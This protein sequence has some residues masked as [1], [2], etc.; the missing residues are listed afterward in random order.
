MWKWFKKLET[1]LSAVAFAEAGELETAREL[2][3]A[4]GR[5]AHAERKKA[6]RDHVVPLGQRKRRF[7]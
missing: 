4:Q 7:A 3:R 2:L 5:S 1:S 6:R